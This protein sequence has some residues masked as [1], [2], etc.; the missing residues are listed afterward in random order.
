MAG[1]SSSDDR[2]QAELISDLQDG[3]PKDQKTALARLAEVG[4]AEALDAVVDYLLHHENTADSRVGLE[5]LR[6]LAQKFI[7]GD[8]YALA[9]VVIDFINSGD[10]E[11][12]L[13]AIRLL[14]THPN[15]MATDAV[16]E[17]VTEAEEFLIN[18]TDYEPG[19]SLRPVIERVLA[20]GIMAM[21][22]CGRMLAIEDVMY[23][24]DEPATK[25]VATRALGI[26]GSDTDRPRLEDLAEDDDVHVRDAAQWALG[27]MDERERQFLTPPDQHPD[28]PPDRLHPLYWAHRLLDASDDALEQ[29]LVVRVALE[30]FLLDA[31]LPTGQVPE[32]VFITLRRFE[33]DKPPNH[34][35]NEAPIVS[36]WRYYFDGPS[37]VPTEEPSPPI[38]PIKKPGSRSKQQRAASITISYPESMDFVDEGL[39]SFDYF[40]PPFQGRGWIYRVRYVDDEWTFTPVRRTWST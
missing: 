40:F 34:R 5:S 26:I 11:A 15:E 19:A 20:E 29:F 35:F 12:R 38:A 27:L 37:L 32:T 4:E 9:E 36:K 7:P 16:R 25:S 39:V 21:A 6:V 22:N 13:H 8:R 24:L 2:T 28:P 23:Y 1:L 33:G 30:H 14:N 17:A 18:Q 3:S 31:M 10:W